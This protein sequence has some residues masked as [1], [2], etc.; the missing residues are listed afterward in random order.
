VEE[1][2]PTLET[3]SDEGVQTTEDGLGYED[4]GPGDYEAPPAIVTDDSDY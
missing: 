1:D 4:P 3:S 2:Y